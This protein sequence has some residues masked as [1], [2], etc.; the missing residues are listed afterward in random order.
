MTLTLYFGPGSCALASLVAL[1]EA[2]ADYRP[3]KLALSDGAQR[4]PNFLKLNPKGQV[5]ALGLDSGEIVTEGP[6]IVQMI[7]DQASA[8]ALAPAHGSSE[9]YKLLEWLNFLT[10][11]VHKSFSPLFGANSDEMKAL[12][13]ERVTKRLQWVDTQLEGKDYL[14][15]KTFSVA[16]AYLFTVASWRAYAQIDTAPWPHLHAFMAR[17]AQRPAVQA[18][19]SA[20]GLKK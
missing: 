17:M 2:E 1:E 5:P 15:G 18:A 19:L 20:E 6:V 3:V 14:L 9:R 11:E 8:K 10:S 12:A 13:R 4:T 7:A 16:D